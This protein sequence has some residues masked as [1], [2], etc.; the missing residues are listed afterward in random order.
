MRNTHTSAYRAFLKR[1]VSARERAGLTQQQVATALGIP[2]SRVS[3]MESGERRIDVIELAIFAKLYR[4]TIGWF[5]SD[6]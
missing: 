4:R 1:L 6:K 2:Q 3:R 5:V